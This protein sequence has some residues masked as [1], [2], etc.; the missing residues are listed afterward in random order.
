MKCSWVVWTVVGTAGVDMVYCSMA[1]SCLCIG[2]S[3]LDDDILEDGTQVKTDESEPLLRRD[4]V[5]VAVV[6]EASIVSDES[7]LSSVGSVSNDSILHRRRGSLVVVA[8][9]VYDIELVAVTV[10][11]LSFE[12]DEALLNLNIPR[13]ER[14]L[15]NPPILFRSCDC[16]FGCCSCALCL[17][18]AIILRNAGVIMI[19]IK[20]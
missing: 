13:L 16:C 15:L 11:I 7:E 8:L 1:C 14:L 4:L 10:S 9:L 20:E 12:S 17:H 6:S 18:D 3:E 19:M 2:R 5:V